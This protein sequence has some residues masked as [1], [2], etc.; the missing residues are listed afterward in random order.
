V[1]RTILIVD[2]EPAIADTLDYALR[3]EGFNTHCV[4]LGRQA[5]DAV[6]QNDIAVVI[7]D[8]GLPDMNGFDVCRELR[9]ESDVPVIFLTARSDEVDRIVGLELG[10]DDYVP[11]PFSP[12]EVASRV[13]AILRRARPPAAP[14]GEP[15]SR[16][17][18]DAEGARIAYDGVWLALTRYEYR[19]LATLLERPGRVFSR[20]RLMELVWSDAQ[21]SLDRTVDAHIKTLRAKLRAVRDDDPIQTHRGFGYSIRNDAS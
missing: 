6:R 21:E 14:A 20:V 9:R 3:T 17:R 10:A 7:L 5:L 18:V 11:K 1:K 16:F 2:D 4:G 15:T 8:V 13:R 19:L 12:R